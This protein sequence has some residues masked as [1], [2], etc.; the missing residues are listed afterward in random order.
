MKKYLYN[1]T[2]NTNV[3]SFLKND[4]IVILGTV[5]ELQDYKRRRRKDEYDSSNS[6]SD[7]S[8]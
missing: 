3:W 6:D 7:S 8:S 2:K 1:G 4:V 5:P